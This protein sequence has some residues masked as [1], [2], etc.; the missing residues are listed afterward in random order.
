MQPEFS[1][2]GECQP[3]FVLKTVSFFGVGG[4]CRFLFS[5]FDEACLSEFLKSFDLPTICF[6]NFS[7]VLI[8]DEGLDLAVIDL[9]KHLNKIVFKEDSVE[10]GAGVSLPRFINE[11]ISKGLSCLEQL[12][13]IPGTIGGAVSMNAGIP[14]FEISKALISVTC[15]EKISG[16]IVI[17]EKGSLN[18]KY[19]NG[20]IN[21]NLIIVSAKF[22]TQNQNPKILKDISM[23]LFEKRKKTQPIGKRTC[24]STFKNPEGFRAWK[25]IKESGC[26]KLSVGDAKVSEMHCN[27]LINSG[28]AK[29]SD[30]FKLIQEIKDRVLKRTGI[31]LEEEIKILGSF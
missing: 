14:E 27:F 10:V 20:N 17:L 12:S 16:K 7:N 23:A 19:R 29:A 31:L 1:N 11:C 4:P 13:C 18:M 26:D 8:S 2:F 25:L 6:G 3:D 21:D 15:V 24:G 28:N 30:F 22:K 9:K 5:P